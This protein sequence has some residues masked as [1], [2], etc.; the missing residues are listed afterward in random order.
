[1]TTVRHAA[2]LAFV[3][4]LA[5]ACSG[6]SKAGRTPTPV[7]VDAQPTTSTPQSSATQRTGPPPNII[8]ILTD[9]QDAAS[10]AKMPNVQKLLVQEGTFFPNFFSSLPLCC[11][12]RTTILRGQYA[13]NTGIWKNSG[14]DGGFGA[15]QAKGLGD[16]TIGTWLDDAG[17]RTSL[18]GK[19]LN[20]YT[21]N[22]S[23]PFI[24]PG[25]DDWH[26]FASG[27]G[28]VR[29]TLND[30]GTI[31]SFA[32]TAADYSTDVLADRALAFVE[33]SVKADD[34]FF[35]MFAPFAPH[36]AA[37]S[38]SRHGAML[39][40]EVGPRTANLNE[41]DVSDKPAWVATRNALTAEELAQ[42]DAEYRNRLRTI[43]AVDDAVGE[44]VAT[45]EASGELD[46]TYIFFTSDNGY[47]FGEHRIV[48]GKQTPYEEVSRV[49]L[50]VRGP[51]VPKGKVLP[52]LTVN[53]DL[54]P[55]FAE[56]AGAKAPTFVDGRSLVPLLTTSST[57]ESAWRKS[58]LFE[59]SAVR[60]PNADEDDD[61]KAPGYSAIRMKDL[62][63]I[64]YLTGERELYDLAKDPYQLENLAAKTD[65][66][67]LARYSAALAKLK[68]C[69]AT[70][71][72]AAE[73]AVP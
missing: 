66:S 60:N 37:R 10:F 40:S 70:S 56:L 44:L 42:I 45:L 34:P 7:T 47:H 5:A 71:C 9:D 52:H 53:T 61:P 50:V 31:N 72:K 12:A 26:V 6:G 16:S 73:D 20:G 39:A 69:A 35:L 64:E 24:L 21:V 19:L 22:Q 23:D 17:Y 38:A 28:Y 55:T 58:V 30:N 49:S 3:L 65:A 41:P 18:S 25:F 48:K 13:H 14:A 1:M 33:E 59:K 27:P 11:P 2:L 4:A 63:Y 54:A 8:L 46:N 15:F 67:T 43:Q 68:S 32:N 29:Y 51:G 57:A 62:V 36:G